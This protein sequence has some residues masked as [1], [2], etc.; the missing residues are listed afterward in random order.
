MNSQNHCHNC[1]YNLNKIDGL[2]IRNIDL[3]NQLDHE[4]FRIKTVDKIL[5]KMK[6]IITEMDDIKSF[7]I[8]NEI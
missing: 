1:Q 2:Y 7:F 8:Q 6:S 4:R 5:V 3:Q